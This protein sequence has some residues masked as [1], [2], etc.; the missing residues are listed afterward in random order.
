MVSCSPTCRRVHGARNATRDHDTRPCVLKW[1]PYNA[2]DRAPRARD[3]A[4]D[5]ERAG[6]GV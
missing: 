3:R 6:T 1:V 4:R 2:R 5:R